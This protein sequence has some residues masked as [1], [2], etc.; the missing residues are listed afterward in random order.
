MSLGHTTHTV[1]EAGGFTFPA[2]SQFLANLSFIGNDPV[3]FKQ[4]AK[5]DPDRFIGPDGK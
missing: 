1:T 3:Y 4:P 5:F 2:G